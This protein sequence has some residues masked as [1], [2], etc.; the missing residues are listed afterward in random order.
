VA[1]SSDGKLLPTASAD[2]T[3]QLWNLRFTSWVTQGCKIV[4]RN[5]SI[6]E[7]GELARRGPTYE[8]PARAYSP[9]RELQK[10]LQPPPTCHAD[11][12]L[13]SRRRTEALTDANLAIVE[14]D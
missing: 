3:T 5:L 13:R 8:E 6:T 10:T 14:C 1:F 12:Q 4:N 2:H 11:R 9:G 7:W